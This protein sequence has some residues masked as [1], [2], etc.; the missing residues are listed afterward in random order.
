[1]V[2]LNQIA[3]LLAI[4]AF[5]TATSFNRFQ[6]VNFEEDDFSDGSSTSPDPDTSNS[7]TTTSQ[8][9]TTTTTFSLDET[10]AT[11]GPFSSSTEGSGPSTEPPTNEVP[12]VTDAPAEQEPNSK[13]S[14]MG[15]GGA[16]GQYGGDSGQYGSG[17]QY[18]DAGGQYGSGG[19]YGGGSGQYGSGGQY[20]GQSGSGGQYGGQYGSSGYGSG[21]YYP[22]GQYGGYP[23]SQYGGGYS[24]YGYPYSSGYG[25]QYGSGFGGQYGQNYPYSSDEP[26]TGKIEEGA[27]VPKQDLAFVNSTEPITVHINVALN[28]SV[29]P[30][31]VNFNGT[32]Q[33]EEAITSNSGLDSNCDPNFKQQ[34]VDDQYR[35]EI[36]YHEPEYPITIELNPEE[37]MDQPRNEKIEIHIKNNIDTSQKEPRVVEVHHTTN[38]CASFDIVCHLLNGVLGSVGTLVGAV[39]GGLATIIGTTLEGVSKVTG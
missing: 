35:N 22:Y 32:L 18:G 3:F 5:T 9:Q 27:M 4:V 6:R 12:P 25:G 31:V 34:Q 21:Q 38:N 37:E 15:N 20:G 39:S 33:N 26:E 28:S 2:R 30:D 1:M 24:G 13:G 29:Q 16:G 36:I 14:P 8:P 7:E 17:G 23:Y 19:Q 11:D 10:K